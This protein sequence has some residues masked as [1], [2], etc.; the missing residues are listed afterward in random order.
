MIRI[1][2]IALRNL[3][4]YKRRTLLTAMLITLGVLMVI[5][6]SGLAG[7]F[8]SMMIGQITDS[9]IAQMQIHKK[10]YVSSIDTSPLHLTI[11]QKGY[12]KV[13][14]ILK[15][16]PDVEAF[17]PRIKLSAMLSNYKETTNIRLN[18]I[19]PEK[20]IKVCPNVS[21]RMKFSGSEVPD[22]VL[23]P[24]EIIIPAKLAK[25]L[26]IKIGDAVVLVANNKDGSVNG[27]NF[28]VAG[29]IDALMGPQGKEGYMHIKDAQSLL[30]MEKPEIIEIAVRIKNFDKLD[31][32]YLDLKSTLGEVKNKKGK[33]AFEIHTWEKL[34]PF[35][36]IAKM[37]DLMTISMKSTMIAIVLISILN[38]MMM[39]V[40]ER[41]REIGT[42]AAIGTSP[43][44]IMGLFL[45][46]GLS[47]GVISVLAGNIIGILGI[48]MLNIYKI[49]FAF[50]R[51]DNILLSP[52]ISFS[53]LAWVSVIVILVSVFAS[54]QPAYKASRMEPV[55]ALGHV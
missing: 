13:G 50:G 38:V 41:V 43:G 8:K 26:K 35:S 27:L 17:A 14:K 5:L 51:M 18:A 55:D 29:I 7:S 19:D 52:T 32:V 36:N 31:N 54:L 44:K 28:T 25:G 45:A 47:L 23:K 16:N 21:E 48:Y 30:R 33:P 46:E 24:G 37:I 6:F 1:F 42:M 49:R 4:R 20:E 22:I 53:E 10:G 34:S 39:S 9:N 2:K 3:M 40:Y 12:K 15:E 11:N